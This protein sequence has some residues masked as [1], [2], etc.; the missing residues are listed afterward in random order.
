M[1]KQTRPA[2]ATIKSPLPIGSLGHLTIFVWA[3]VMALLPTQERGLFATLLALVTL[4]ALY[5]FAI[6]R[7][8]KPRWLLIL[9]SLF[10]VSFFFGRVEA[11][12]DWMVWGFQISSINLLNSARMLLRAV[13]ILMA[14][15]GLS[16]SVN[17]TE[18]AGML[19]RGGLRGLGFS[20]GV[21]FNLL[22]DLR[23]SST[24]TWHSL[25]MRGGLRAKWQRGLQ[26]LLVT[27]LTNS[28]RH[29]EEIVLAAEVR[30][31]QPERNHIIPIKAGKLDGWLIVIGALVLALILFLPQ[32]TLNR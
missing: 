16:A 18:I 11:E 17:I 2:H 20:L 15:D 12:P 23:R 9:V 1:R 29:A 7:L 13:V 30:A 26:L 14:A 5:P 25:R 4:G 21:A 6:Q 27:I 3:L 31:F 28:L 24:A 8:F 19:E 32:F 22:P 10:L